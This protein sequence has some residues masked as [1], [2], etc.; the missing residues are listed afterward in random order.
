MCLFHN[1]LLTSDWVH[2][3]QVSNDHNYVTWYT[4]L[5]TVNIFGFTEVTTRRVEPLEEVRLRWRNM[6]KLSV[7][8][9]LK[10]FNLSG[11]LLNFPIGF[12]N[13]SNEVWLYV[14]MFRSLIQAQSFVPKNL[15]LNQARDDF[16]RSWFFH[17]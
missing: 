7:I 9:V 17:E 4:G 13:L 12:E 2:K 11:L 8:A 10:S 5:K 6:S 16:L 14:I 1:Q 15:I 3:F